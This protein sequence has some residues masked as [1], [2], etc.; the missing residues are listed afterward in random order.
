M[1]RNAVL[2]RCAEPSRFSVRGASAWGAVHHYYDFLVRHGWEVREAFFL[3]KEANTFSSNLMKFGRVLPGC[4]PRGSA[5]HLPLP[6]FDAN[7]LTVL[8]A[9]ASLSGP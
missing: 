1:L 6:K 5:R 9:S 3:K 7:A 2:S 4:G 8:D